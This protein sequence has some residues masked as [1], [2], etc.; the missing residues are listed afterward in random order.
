MEI[1]VT[2][3]A[4]IINYTDVVE[5]GRISGLFNKL[6]HYVY[7]YDWK[8]GRNVRNAK[9]KYYIHDKENKVIRTHIT[10]KT[11]VWGYIKAIPGYENIPIT[12]K[13]PTIYK[14]IDIEFNSKYSLSPRQEDYRDFISDTSR[15]ISILPAFMGVGKTVISLNSIT[16]LKRKTA[17]VI[18]PKYKD[19]WI[20]SIN[21]FLDVTEED[22]VYING[23][24]ALVDYMNL[25]LD[26]ADNY[27]IVM[28]ST[29]TIQRFIT[30]YDTVEYPLTPDQLFDLG[31]FG[32]KLVDEAHQ[33]MHLHML[34]DLYS[35][36]EIHQFLTATLYQEGNFLSRME[37]TLYPVECR[38]EVDPPTRHVSLKVYSY[39]IEGMLPAYKT[40]RGYSH[41]KFESSIKANP[42]WLERYL[43]MY[44]Y[45]IKNEFLDYERA[46]DHKCLIYFSTLDI[47]DRFYN[48]VRKIL[49]DLNP[50]AYTKDDTMDML[51]GKDLIITTTKK[52]GTGVDIKG[53]TRVIRTINISSKNENYQNI[54]R[55]RKI[56]DD[57]IETV[58]VY[59]YC[60][61]IDKQVYYHKKIM[62]DVKPLIYR[63]EELNLDHSL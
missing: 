41:S 30:N 7:D 55:L 33:C 45:I 49:P 63:C 27:K 46:E 26:A 58:F 54:G 10:H 31:G 25:I 2:T 5:V 39:N 3:S 20:G 29:N 22:Y 52:C 35:N 1:I 44:C 6:T 42:R 8:T 16:Y 53:L 14:V 38:C 62:H 15:H 24:D 12:I 13:D 48:L 60:R 18:A 36:I 32:V 37:G 50:I 40:H 28:F 59:A 34:I 57:S 47:I 9:A 23:K 4:V 19:N 43:M 21:K 17:I 56:E 11:T 51:E 61:R